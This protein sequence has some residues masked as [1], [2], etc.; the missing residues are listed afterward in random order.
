MRRPQITFARD[1]QAQPLTP[2]DAPRKFM[3]PHPFAMPRI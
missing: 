2:K 3:Q 1:A